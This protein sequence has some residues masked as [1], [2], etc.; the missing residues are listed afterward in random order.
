M[1]NAPT[2]YEKMPDGMLVTQPF[3]QV[4]DGTAN[5][6][7]SSG[8]NPTE[9]FCRHIGIEAADDKYYHQSE[10]QVQEGGKQLKAAGKEQFKDGAGQHQGPLYAQEYKSCEPTNI[11][12][13]KKARGACNQEVD[14]DMVQHFEGP[15]CSLFSNGMVNSR[16]NVYHQQRNPIYDNGEPQQR[17]R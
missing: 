1:A 16:I 8:Y 9:N 3:P 5:I 15:L 13:Y 17:T 4:K 12:S 7:G 14:A 11:Q 2:Q 6:T 10:T